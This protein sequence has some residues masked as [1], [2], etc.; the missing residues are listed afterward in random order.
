VGRWDSGHSSGSS[1]PVARIPLCGRT[2]YDPVNDPHAARATWAAR[3]C[4]T[5]TMSVRSLC[6]F[7]ASKWHEVSTKLDHCKLLQEYKLSLQLCTGNFK[8]FVH[9]VDTCGRQEPVAS[10]SCFII[11][12]IFWLLE[13]G[14][15]REI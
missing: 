12:M 10:T 7:V 15:S 9:D 2:R 4:A 3:I 5:V 13:I 1:V 8:G 11:L 6:N 14:W